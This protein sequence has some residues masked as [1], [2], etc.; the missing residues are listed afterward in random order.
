MNWILILIVATFFLFLGAIFF[1]KK[2]EKIE[3]DYRT[4]FIIGTTWLPLG[5]AMNN[6]F[7]WIMSLV[8]MG[9]GLS[10]KDKWRDHKKWKEL[11]QKERSLKMTIIVVLGILLLVGVGAF[12]W[13]K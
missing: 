9:V 3:P 2:G 10:N 5:L 13:V 4:L 1:F 11:D 6:S 8:L 12:F 7:F